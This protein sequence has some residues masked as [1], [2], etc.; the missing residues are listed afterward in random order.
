MKR[1]QLIILSISVLLLT[2]L[3]GVV[4]ALW[5]LTPVVQVDRD[6]VS[7]LGGMVE[8]D[9]SGAA[10]F[11]EIEFEDEE[12]IKSRAWK[13][14]WT[15]KMNSKKPFVI[16]FNN[17]ALDIVGTNKKVL[18]WGCDL[19]GGNKK[20]LPQ[21]IDMTLTDGID[22]KIYVPKDISLQITALN[23]Q[24][25]LIG[26]KGPTKVTLNNG[27]VELKKGAQDLYDIR[28]EVRRGRGSDIQKQEGAPL[29]DV[30]I[31]NGQFRVVEH[32]GS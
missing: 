28:A 30:K 20:F 17:G 3:A 16:A 25:N 4:F 5:K 31:R 24:V 12:F 19:W 23:G 6:R 8:I 18:S 32:T 9:E 22:C 26:P 21:G 11:P 27:H 15:K 13:G 2:C 14:N 1:Y 29:I 7:I 10:S